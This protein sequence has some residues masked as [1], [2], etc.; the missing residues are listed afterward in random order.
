MNV[1]EDGKVE[2]MSFEEAMRELESLVKVL[3]KGELDLKSS[4]AIFE[5]AAVLR[6]HCQRILDES[7]RRVQ[8]IVEASE[9]IEIEDFK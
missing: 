8:K 2:E 3:E 9:S 7:E 4:L 5:R 1:S 6:E